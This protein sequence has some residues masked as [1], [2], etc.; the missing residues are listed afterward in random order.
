MRVVV[1]GSEGGIG[2]Y[3]VDAIAETLPRAR[4]VR[5]SRQPPQR[6]HDAG[7]SFEVGDLRDRPF[8]RRVLRGA[9][10]VVHLAAPRYAP[11]A[12]GYPAVEDVE[13]G[14][15]VVVAAEQESVGSIAFASSATVYDMALPGAPLVESMTERIPPPRSRVGRAKIV[16]EAA[17]RN[18]SERTGGSCT[19]WRL[20]SVLTPLEPHNRPGHVQVDLFRRI[21]V[22]READVEVAEG[23][24]RRSF[25]WVGDAAQAIVAHLLDPR[26]RR[27]TFNLCGRDA[28]LRELAQEIADSACRSRALRSAP[29]VRSGPG[30]H[31]VVPHGAAARDELGW[32]APTDLRAAVDRFVLGKIDEIRREALHG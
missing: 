3:V 30:R 16:V 20:G 25:L 15:S 6:D 2:R 11:G 5:V 19:I 13:I 27:R 10:V 17:L 29:I 22:D 23:E 28:S 32:V 8:A 18:W 26:V 12:D 1:T 24:S 21:V 7:T 4:L 9:D 31:D 14:A